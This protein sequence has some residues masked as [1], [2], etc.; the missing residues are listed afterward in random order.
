MRRRKVWAIFLSLA[1]VLGAGTIM[2]LA[3][4]M[5][6]FSFGMLTAR[7]LEHQLAVWV[8]WPAFGLA[9]LLYAVG[10]WRRRRH[11]LP[12]REAFGEA[13]RVAFAIFFGGLLSLSR[14]GGIAWSRPLVAALF[15]AYVV[16][17]SREPQSSM[18]RRLMRAAAML[19]VGLGTTWFIRYAAS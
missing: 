9:A 5:K 17:D 2:F 11:A 19:L 10:A 4:L 16:A 14:A 15:L 8:T 6:A 3:G 7:E 13:S 12:H 18:K 1:F